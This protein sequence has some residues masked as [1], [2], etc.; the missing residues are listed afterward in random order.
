MANLLTEFY[1]AVDFVGADDLNDFIAWEPSIRLL[2][3]FRQF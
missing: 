1:L 2:Q 3:G